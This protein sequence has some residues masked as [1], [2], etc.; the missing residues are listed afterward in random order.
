[1]PHFPRS[2]RRIGFWITIDS[3]VIFL[4]YFASLSLRAITSQLDYLFSLPFILI[5]ILI[6]LVCLYRFHIY[7]IVWTQT[8]GNSVTK[9]IQAFLFAS[10]IIIILDLIVTPRPLP[11]SVI[12]AEAAFALSAMVIIRY[13][14]RLIRGFN[15]ALARNLE[16]RISRD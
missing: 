1:M 4:S 14:G 12:V 13:R 10:P 3:L 7:H 11:F 9:I 5:S 16:F 6:T 2:L 15:L 8:S